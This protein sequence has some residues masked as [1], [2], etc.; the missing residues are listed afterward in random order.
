MVRQNQ[1]HKTVSTLRDKWRALPIFRRIPFSTTWSRR[2]GST[3]GELAT[4]LPNLQ[5]RR[6]R[7][8]ASCYQSPI[9][10]MQI[11][12]GDTS[13]CSFSEYFEQ[14]FYIRDWSPE[15]VWTD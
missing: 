12:V 14:V 1:L 3:T 15:F 5:G 8:P 13:F 4:V 7:H 9:T 11:C 2:L 10:A 6:R